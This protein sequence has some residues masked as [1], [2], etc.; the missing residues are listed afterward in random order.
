MPVT[1]GIDLGGTGTRFVALDAQGV[2]QASLSVPTPQERDQAGPA[3][4]FQGH[5]AAVVQQN[6]LVAIGIGSPV[7]NAACQL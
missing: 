1:V 3:A 5:I 7:K 4:F 6:R 2:V